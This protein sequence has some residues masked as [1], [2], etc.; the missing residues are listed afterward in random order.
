LR[1]GRGPAWATL[2]KLMRVLGGDL[3]TLGIAGRTPA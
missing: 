1:T 3:A 2:V